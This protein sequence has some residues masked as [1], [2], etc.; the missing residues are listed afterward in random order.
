M[1][2]FLAGS[3]VWAGLMAACSPMINVMGR[4]VPDS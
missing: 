3:L 2:L 4:N 1:L